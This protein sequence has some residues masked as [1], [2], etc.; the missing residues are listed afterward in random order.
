MSHT[1]SKAPPGSDAFFER[2]LAAFK[3]HMPSVWQ[4][5]ETIGTP[6]SKLV[7]GPD[8]AMNI[9]LGSV[10]L[11]DRDARE[12]TR[13]QLDEYFKLPDRLKFSTVSHCNLIGLSMAL[14]QSTRTFI[15]EHMSPEEFVELPV[16]DIG[17]CY[18]F[19]VGL[20]Y[21]LEE[22]LERTHCRTMIIVEPTPELLLHS[23]RAIDWVA[24][25]EQA[26]ARG[27]DVYVV[28][29]S[30]P[31]HV[32]E[33]IFSIQDKHGR[34]FL[35]G[36]YAYHHYYSW[37][38]K[39]IRELI[40]TKMESYHWSKGYFEDELLMMGNTVGNFAR[41]NH[42]II[43]WEQRLHQDT[44]VLVVGSGPSLDK[45][46]PHIARLRDQAIILS[47][48]TSLGILLK[49]GIR[50]D[51]HLENENTY[52]LVNNLI[53]FKEEYGLEGI[54]LLGSSSIH[55]E[56][57]A[58]FDEVWY[59]YRSGLSCDHL[60]NPGYHAIISAGPLV[61]NAGFAAVSALGFRRLYLFGVDCGRRPDASHHSKDVVYLQDDY[62]NWLA[63]SSLKGLEES[64]N[65]VVEGNF[66]GKIITSWK[67]AYSR[68]QFSRIQSLKNLDIHNCSDGAAIAGARPQA[69]AA[70]RLSDM[71]LPREAVI[72]SVR[73]QLPHY[74]AGKGLNIKNLKT[75]KESVES[76]GSGIKLI[77]EQARAED[78]LFSELEDRI[79]NWFL[80]HKEDLKGVLVLA[81]ESMASAI[82]VGAY[83]AGRI[84]NE[85]LRQEFLAMFLDKFDIMCASITETALDAYDDYIDQAKAARSARAGSPGSI[86]PDPSERL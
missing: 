58:Q 10:S 73:E 57:S 52:P 43:P 20:G 74:A 17:Y 76:F 1:V 53:K 49:H 48:G 71:D 15:D 79:Q 85:D 60:L 41:F 30:E 81:R 16:V 72:R 83:M 80:E 40:N 39:R 62:D 38:L 65:Q 86:A 25:W 13:Q 9:D 44:P 47:C 11:Y 45:D 7:S 34:T 32:S 61:A 63:G 77:I 31:E 42:A 68:T 23:M 14:F 69:A 21:H 19:G 59:Y 78:R 37:T 50:P 66:G 29:R 35:N 46:L 82:R 56:A 36:S 33:T 55:P 24:L 4:L 3:T 54:V 84:D 28:I 22:L 12:V 75:Y 8:G 5:L 51:F 6:V 64:F 27:Q 67:L 2:N 70:L 26:A 18:V